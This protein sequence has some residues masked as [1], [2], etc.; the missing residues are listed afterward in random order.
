[1]AIDICAENN[2]LVL[3]M[4]LT[5]AAFYVYSVAITLIFIIFITVLRKFRVLYFFL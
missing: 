2:L 1:M 4:L 5:K 3:N